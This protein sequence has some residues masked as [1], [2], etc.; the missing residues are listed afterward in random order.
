MPLLHFEETRMRVTTWL[1]SGRRA[2]V[3]VPAL[4]VVG[5]LILSSCQA[6]TAPATDV[7]TT[8]ATLNATA[9]CS[10]GTPVP[11][12]WYWRWGT[13][14]N[15]QF[16]SPLQGPA[17][18]T[19]SGTLSYAVTG[20][21]PGTTYQYQLCGKGDSVQSYECVGPYNING[22]QTFT[23]AS[24]GS[25]GTSSGGSSGSG[26]GSTGPLTAPSGYSSN[27]LILDDNFSGTTLNSNNWVTYLGASGV[28]W[29]N[30]G[31]LPS[32]Y[33]GQNTPITTESAMFGPSQVSVNNGLTLT[34]QRNTNQYSGTYPWISGVV[35]T[36]G[37]FSLPSSGPWYVQVRAKM[38]DQSQGMWPAIW[39]MP[40]PA[41]TATNEFDGYEGGFSGTPA[42]DIMHSD[43]FANQG[44][45][46][47]AYNLNTDTSGGYHN[48]GFQFLPG[49]SITA[50]FDGKQVWQVNASS[51]VTITG[52]PYEIILELQVAASQDSGWHTV[53]NS[54]TPTSSM[55]VSEVQAYN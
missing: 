52:E 44:Q 9:S 15:F 7:G 54:K 25:G 33:S 47:D 39:F 6:V 35:S 13:N 12:S 32:P 34:A 41:G 29:N 46:Q 5:V 1:K 19:W 48:Y 14:D 43:Y 49:K 50:Y 23:T 26:S 36:E 10:G 17:Q 18:T 22:F 38:S 40:G 27:Q 16:Q 53:T 2:R 37:K 24:T 8:T 4:A 51:G 21:T 11:C 20:L 55:T 31:A 30:N 3:A 28:R 42:N 45:Q